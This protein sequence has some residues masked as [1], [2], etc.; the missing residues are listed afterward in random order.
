MTGASSSAKRVKVLLVINVDWYFLSHRL[1]LAKALRARGY[2]VAVVAGAERGLGSKI[3]SEGLRFI[4]IPLERRSMRP[5]R[6]F[7]TFLSLW[8]LYRRESPDV[9]HHVTIKPVLYGSIASRLA[10]VPRVINAI[11]GLGYMFAATGWK[12]RLRRAL[13]MFAY[14]VAAS[15]SMR[16]IFQNSSDRDLFCSGGVVNE[17]QA[18]LIRGAGVD[19]NR[20]RSSPEPEG[21][22]IVLLASRLLWDKGIGVF[23]AAARI[24]KQ[25]GTVCRMVVVGSP[26]THNPNAVDELTMRSWNDE[27]LVEWWGERDD[28][29]RVFAMSA[30]AVL[31]TSYP[32]GVPK[33]LL[34]AAASGR[35]MIATDVPGCRDIVLGGINGFVVPQSDPGKLADAIGMLLGDPGLRRRMGQA[36][37]A[38][39]EREFSEEKVI[40]ETLALYDAL[41]AGPIISR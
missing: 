16:F 3:E 41:L 25:R 30:I 40:S 10:R 28:M 20:F 8:R 6:E 4:P 19:V 23:A 32:E 31:P 29:P 21:T 27:G 13:V 33:V 36:G 12:G 15:R 38:L 24:L 34:E 7:A 17:S 1:P 35:P 2:D 39:V 22:P 14:R 9:V 11:P 5:H 18:R 37:R 26:D